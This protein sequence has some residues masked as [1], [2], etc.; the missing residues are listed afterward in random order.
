MSR[1]IA[2]A[3]SA[4]AEAWPR[5][6]D[7]IYGRFAEVVVGRS[8]VPLEGG[9][10]LDV[11]AGTGAASRVALAVGAASV[12][13]VDVA[14]GML[15]CDAPQRPPGVVG[16]ALALPFAA[17]TFDAAVA[18]FSLNHLT[19]PASGL[20][21]MARVTRPRG[22][23]LAAAFGD[24]DDHPV[25]AAVEQALVAWGWAPPPWY[26]TVQVEAAP[27]LAAPQACLA[28]ATAAG[29]D[30]TVDVVRVSFPD[31]DARQLVATRLG[32]AQYDPF[33][34][35]LPASDRTALVG[36]AVAALGEAVPPLMRSVLVLAAV[37]PGAG[38]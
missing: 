38:G 14:F 26:V 30:A 37:R 7:R 22:A 18:A 2:S 29:L 15:A 16:D 33:V 6:P 25:K 21:E 27:R 32:L 9:R 20:R 34:A 28:A 5:G 8:P 19:D 3:Y 36:T 13:A 12:V 24:G 35:S 10:V 1:G 23:I 31:L 17:W 11:G 4:T